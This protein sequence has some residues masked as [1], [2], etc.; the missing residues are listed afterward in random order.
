MSSVIT[1][2]F[3][4]LFGMMFIILGGDNVRDYHVPNAGMH[5]LIH[6]LPSPQSYMTDKDTI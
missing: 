5:S 2:D 4:M 1:D 6:P 3:G